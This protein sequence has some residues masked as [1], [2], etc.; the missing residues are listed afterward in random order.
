MVEPRPESFHAI[1]GDGVNTTQDESPEQHVGAFLRE[2]RENTGR[3]VEDVST[4]LR[5]GTKFLKSIEDGRFD[6]LPGP[7]YA[8]GFIR[9]YADYLGLDSD[10]LVA[11]FKS[12]SSGAEQQSELEFPIPTTVGWFPT[13]KVVAICALL[14][15]VVFAGWFV[16]QNE[17]AIDVAAIPLPPGFKSAI[18]GETADSEPREPVVVA[19]AASAD[20]QTT[21]Q[22]VVAAV[23]TVDTPPAVTEAQGTSDEDE[24]PYFL[25]VPIASLVLP[26]PIATEADLI[27]PEAAEAVPDEPVSI[28]VE[29]PPVVAAPVTPEP[30]PVAAVEPSVP[31]KDQSPPVA[32]SVAEPPPPPPVVAVTEPQVAALPTIPA[33]SGAVNSDGG[34][35]TYGVINKEARVIIGA[36]AD[37]WVQV[38]DDNQNVVLTRLL[39]AGDR[40]LVPNRQ[41]L[42]MST[43]NAG[44]LVISVDGAPVPNIG[45]EGAI[46]H[47]V[48]LDV[49]LLKAGQA[50]VQ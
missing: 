9:S 47:N 38:L 27:A 6:D 44:G 50:V 14:A 10:A 41:D 1:E 43:G 40:Y 7:T 2:A 13:G 23:P 35:R 30:T 33:D 28:P 37:S 4:T 45:V 20:N 15:A 24:K 39:R 12:Q 32:D 48:R 22:P 16:I 34:G 18:A 11:Q 19:A 17:D 5:I 21:E 29:P 31:A 36:Q 49:E 42:V 3:T 26:D 25:P 46:L 8:T